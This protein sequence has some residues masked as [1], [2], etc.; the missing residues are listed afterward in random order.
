MFECH[1]RFERIFGKISEHVELQNR[2]ILLYQSLPLQEVTSLVWPL[3]EA[4]AY[5]AYEI[6]HVVGQKSA[7]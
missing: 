4:T 1:V 7:E 5:K 6:C 2:W 3:V